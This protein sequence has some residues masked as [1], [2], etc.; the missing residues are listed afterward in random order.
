MADAVY[1]INGE[2][3][4]VEYKNEIRPQH[5]SIFDKFKST[6][7]PFLVVAKY[8]TPNAKQ[9]LKNNG[10]NYIDSFGNAFLDLEHLKL[11]VEKNNAKPVYK[12]STRIFT[13][14]GCQLVFQ[15]LKHPESINETV[16]YLAH[17]CSIS[18]GSISKI[19]NHLQ[20]EGYVIKWNSEQ[21]YQLVK[22]EEL[23]E[24][25]I[26]PFV[27][28]VLPNYKVGNFKFSQHQLSDWQKKLSYPRLF[29]CGEPAASMLTKN[30][31]PEKF[32]IYTNRTKKEISIQFRLI[33]DEN[34]AITVY[35]K[36]WQ[37][38]SMFDEL[39]YL[40]NKNIVHPLLIYAELIHSGSQR[41]IETGKIIFDEYIKP[42]L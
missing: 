2:S 22:R 37:E 32:T 26:S 33:P 34:G 38:K 7:L 31:N 13:Q 12:S 6:E 28:K 11:Y 3:V 16:R 25:W 20:E 15:L 30:L 5:V 27:E 4:L 29:W 8:I 35:N 40:E 18:I 9:A 41:N 14:A 24:R 21:K 39:A 36:F 17:H 1:S 23:L 42:N 19:I 10:V